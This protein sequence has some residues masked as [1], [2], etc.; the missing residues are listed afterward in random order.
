MNFKWW[1]TFARK[2]HRFL[3]YPTIILI[4]A[5]IIIRIIAPEVESSIKFVFMGQSLI[6]LFLMITG[7]LLFIIPKI[8][9][10]MKKKPR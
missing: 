6:M 2:A 1:Y 4:P 8:I 7:V 9:V 3:A 10:A 5:I